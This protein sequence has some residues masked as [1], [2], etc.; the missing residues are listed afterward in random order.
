MLQCFSLR[1]STDPTSEKQKGNAAY[2]HLKNKLDSLQKSKYLPTADMY[3]LY[4][5]MYGNAEWS[6][7]INQ[8][9]KT[10][11]NKIK[12]FKENHRAFLKN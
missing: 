7:T 5:C 3:S 11:E 12:A 1:K 9:I 8:H 10:D 2:R 4:I 6:E